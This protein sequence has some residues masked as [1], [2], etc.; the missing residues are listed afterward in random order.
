MY[1][2]NLIRDEREIDDDD[3]ED[4]TRALARRTFA[5]ENKEVYAGH[6]V[7]DGNS[8]RT[9]SQWKAVLRHQ[10]KRKFRSFQFY[11]DEEPSGREEPED[12]SVL[13]EVTANQHT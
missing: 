9:L 3:E 8:Q 6:Y 11:D 2:D 4:E 10:E 1:Y 5:E 12:D 13:H 7:D